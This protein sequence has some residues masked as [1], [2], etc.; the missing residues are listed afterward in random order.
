[1]KQNQGWN[2]S[3]I[4][5]SIGHNPLDASPSISGPSKIACCEPEI[6]INRIKARSRNCIGDGIVL[7]VAIIQC[8]H[9]NLAVAAI[10]FFE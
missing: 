3:N 8:V 5:A 2:P 10:Q 4:T 7:E 1:M 9:I 6:V